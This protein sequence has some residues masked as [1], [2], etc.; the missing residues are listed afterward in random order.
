MAT[1]AVKN[2]NLLKGLRRLGDFL[3]PYPAQPWLVRSDFAAD[4]EKL[5]HAA[6][7]NLHCDDDTEVGKA[8]TDMRIE[9]FQCGNGPKGKDLY[10]EYEEVRKRLAICEGVLDLTLNSSE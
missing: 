9:R 3:G 2:P 10:R 4:K 1:L 7:Q 6:L 5:L 8:L